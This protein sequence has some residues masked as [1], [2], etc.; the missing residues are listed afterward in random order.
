MQ[1]AERL[2]L[3][4]GGNQHHASGSSPPLSVPPG[5]A[6]VS[7]VCE[8]SRT[9][10]TVRSIA[11]VG[12][13]PSCRAVS[14]RVHSRYRRRAADLPLAGRSVQLQVLARRFRCDGVLC[15]RQIFTERFP[16]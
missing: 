2:S 5:F 13:C 1:S 12:V 8:E 16:D 10:I 6:V 3:P 4:W 7:T 11:S 15:S 14:R 9:V